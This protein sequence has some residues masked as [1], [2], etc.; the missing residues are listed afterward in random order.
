[1]CFNGSIIIY[2]SKINTRKLLCPT[3]VRSFMSLYVYMTLRLLSRYTYQFIT[4]E[5]IEDSSVVVD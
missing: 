4:N 2:T 5:V 1:M 3:I